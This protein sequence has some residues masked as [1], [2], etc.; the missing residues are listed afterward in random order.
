MESLESI[1]EQYQHFET[2]HAKNH[3]DFKPSSIL[4]DDQKVTAI[5]LHATSLEPVA[6]DMALMTS[7]IVIEYPNMLSRFHL[8]KPTTGWEIPM[9]AM[10]A[11]EYPK[12]EKQR[13]F[14]LLMFLYQ[15]LRRWIVI[16]DRYKNQ[17]KRLLDRGA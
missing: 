12:D 9:L 13:N 4:T 5:D 6:N 2:L 3:G 8:K 17:K 14:F 1:L 10:E 15:L 16:E 7:Y 11:Y